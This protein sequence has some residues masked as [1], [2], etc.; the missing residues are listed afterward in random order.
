MV[1]ALQD[2]RMT[3]GLRHYGC[4]VMPANIVEGA[5]RAI[6]ST[7][8]D[9]RLSAQSCGHE[10]PRL[11]HLIGTGDELPCFAEDVKPL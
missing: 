4:S 11:L 8:N 3:A 9:D 2:L 6:G 10:V 1:G 5:Q 7:N